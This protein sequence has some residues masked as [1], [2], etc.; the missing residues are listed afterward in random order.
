MARAEQLPYP[1]ERIFC[2]HL[3]GHPDH[4]DH[5]DQYGRLE[6]LLVWAVQDSDQ[7]TAAKRNPSKDGS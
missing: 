6:Q 7:Y 1:H 3:L 5:P 2:D 4:P